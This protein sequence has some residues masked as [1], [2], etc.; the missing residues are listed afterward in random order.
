VL[1]DRYWP[2]TLLDFQLHFPEENVARWRL[3]RALQF[4]CPRPHATFLML[5]PLSVSLQRS[6]QKNEPFPTPVDVLENRLQA[7]RQWSAQASYRLLDGQRPLEDLTNE[8]MTVID[9]SVE[10][11][12]DSQPDMTGTS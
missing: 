9:A 5:V 7:Y 8:I 3:W 6:Q 1:C 2:D 10:S 4:V 12:R 11:G